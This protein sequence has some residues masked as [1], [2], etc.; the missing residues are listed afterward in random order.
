MLQKVQ[1]SA[2]LRLLLRA[3]LL[4]NLC[5]SSM[6]FAQDAAAPVAEQAPVE[7]E[8][9]TNP[10]AEAGGLHFG[11]DPTVWVMIFLFILAL[12]VTIERMVVLRKNRGNNAELVKLLADKLAPGNKPDIARLAE[13]VS[14]KQ[15]GVEGRVAGVTLKG[16]P[17]GEQAMREYSEAAIIAEQRNLD[18]RLVILST[19]GNNV[20]FIGLLGTVLGIMKAFR[21]LAM[22]GDG[23]PAVVMKGISEALIATAMGLGVAIPVVLAFNALNKAVKTKIANAQEIATLLR[24]MRLSRESMGKTSLVNDRQS[25][26]PELLAEKVN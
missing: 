10:L 17:Y 2:L 20:P 22:M 23:G 14:V 11:E 5:V 24:A 8:T 7:V 18:K 21:D 19:L 16:W 15:Y 9:E 13:D 25:I 6:L 12:A 26:A 4:F 3:V 1:T